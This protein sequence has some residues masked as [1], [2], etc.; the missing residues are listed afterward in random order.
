MLRRMIGRLGY[1]NV[2]ATA[3]VFLALGG[4]AYALSLPKNSVGT[5][6]IKKHAVTKPKLGK[7][8]VRSFAPASSLRRISYFPTGCPVSTVARC[9]KVIN[10][11]GGTKLEALC[12]DVAGG[13]LVVTLEGTWNSFTTSMVFDGNSGTGDQPT[14]Y[15]TTKAA[16]EEAPLIL[17][18]GNAG[19]TMVIKTK[20]GGDEITIPFH[21][22]SGPGANCAFEGVASRA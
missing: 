7:S 4:G 5:K 22:F 15:G 17:A 19:G 18:S 20:N 21:G 8:A 9:D 11:G 16:N 2:M 13:R 6:Q 12:R 14:V 10:L 3:A 1:A